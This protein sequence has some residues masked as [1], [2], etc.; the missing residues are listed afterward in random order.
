MLGQSLV[1]THISED[2]CTGVSSFH[3]RERRVRREGP[4]LPSLW[5]LRA[6]R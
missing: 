5:S 2:E 1:I 4:F 6:L 3:R